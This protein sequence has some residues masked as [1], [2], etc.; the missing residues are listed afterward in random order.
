MFET[1]VVEKIKTHI[2][3]SINF[4]AVYNIIWKKYCKIGEA[5]DDNMAHAHFTLGTTNKY[6][7]AICNTN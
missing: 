6:S 1:K 5:R 3:W 7:S 4:R 2:F